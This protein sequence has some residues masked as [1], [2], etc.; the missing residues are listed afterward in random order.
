VA[1]TVCLNLIVIN[2][3]S[4]KFQ[5]RLIIACFIRQKDRTPPLLSWERRHC[6]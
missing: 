1:G 5:T 3:L 4:I 6:L 2:D